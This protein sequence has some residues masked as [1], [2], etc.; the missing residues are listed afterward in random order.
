MPSL[1]TL[2][3]DLQ[4]ETGGFVSALNK[5]ASTAQRASKEIS[6]SFSRLGEIASQTFGAFGDFNPAISKLSFAMTAAG[7][8]AS[9]MMK[10]LRGVGGAIGPLAALGAGAGVGLAALAAGAVGVAIETAE[11]AAKMNELSKSTG[12]SASTLGAWTFAAKQSGLEGEQVV[13][14]LQLLSANMLKAAQAPAG[15]AT[16]FSRLGLNIRQS[17]GELKNA[18]DFMIELLGRLSEMS[19]KT[20]AVG[21]ARL[22]MGRGGASMLQL[23]DPE[24]LDR[25]IA[26]FKELNPQFDANAAAATKFKQTLGEISEVAAAAQNQLMGDLLP[27]LQALGTEMSEAIQSPNSDLAYLLK[28]VATVVKG[29]VAVGDT[30]VSAAEQIGLVIRH[31]A[32]VTIEYWRGVAEVGNRALHFDF[33]GMVNASKNAFATMKGDLSLFVADSKAIWKGNADF[34]QNIFGPAP[35]WTL[36]PHPDGGAG[37]GDKTKGAPAPTASREI[38]VVAKL[39][40]TLTAKSAAE[41]AA[42][43]ATE[44]GVAA[45]ALAKAAIEAETKIAETRASL[46]EKEKMLRDQLADARRGVGGAAAG[47]HALNFQAQIDGIE[48]LLAELDSAAPQ[49][50]TLY[51]EIA[52]G[53]FATKASKE[54]EQFT[55][56]TREETTAAE[57][58]TAAY[59]QGG[60]AIQAAMEAAK[61]A[62]FAELRDD[63]GELIAR[64]KEIGAPA[65]NIGKLQTA[66]DQLSAGIDGLRKA[67]AAD[68]S[69]KISEQIAKELALLSGEAKAYEVLAAAA[70]K[71]LAAQ[72]EAAA[73]AA[74]IKFGAEHRAATPQQIQQVSEMELARLSQQNKLTI[75]Q[76]A[77]QFDLA[78]SYQREIEKLSQV[79][80]YM[81]SLGEST[82]TV[83]AKMYETTVQAIQGWDKAAQAVGNLGEKF[84]AMANEI[85]LEGENTSG[86]FFEL[87]KKS[88]DG[89]S[90]ELAKFIVTGKANWKSF[91]DGIAEQMA[92]LA[93]QAGISKIFK[94]LS[95][96]LPGAPGQGAPG[97]TAGAASGSLGI[98]GAIAGAFGIKLPG[99]PG[100]RGPLGTAGDP[101]HVIA[102]GGALGGLA[103]SSPGAPE[104]GGSSGETDGLISKLS[105]SLEGIFSKL[106]SSLGSIVSSIG[107]ALGSMGSSIGSGVA[108]GFSSVIGLF[109]LA[110]GGPVTTGIPQI[111]GEKGMEI[112]VPRESG[113]IVP[114]LA[115]FAASPEVRSMAARFD[116]MNFPQLARREYGGDVSSG[117]PYLTGERRGEG[118]IPDSF[119][120]GGMAARADHPAGHAGGYTSVVNFSVHGVK[121]HDSFSRSKAQIYADQLNQQA[122]AHRRNRQ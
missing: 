36:P 70:G 51:A 52:S 93:I 97:G 112:F 28:T 4:A 91:L 24:E 82:L 98:G 111:V 45:S 23:G 47:E 22:T 44:K 8:A 39:I 84:R 118:F 103:P 21:F 20:A 59:S 1:G 19:D 31:W 109:G 26:K 14:S 68:E 57:L 37:S 102:A 110:G 15:V 120:S 34:I 60:A 100:G 66:F 106:T 65:A 85:V 72:R 53:E 9:A 75:A 113:R 117:I 29:I 73:Q 80:E 71:S 48:K 54:L 119:R 42:A 79:R 77:A 89:I 104:G 56:K 76:T 105:S 5:A 58:M 78:T 101:I 3:V 25:W 94:A 16:A 90:D 41:L 10:E 121:D 17:N 114:S 87:W 7:S 30:L 107:G 115:Q 95:P 86:K 38:D 46:L 81:Q 122:I 50:K 11:S 13:K 108:S 116:V 49:I 88:V 61:I 40:E 12:L 67:T 63:V 55:T 74:A 99:A 6:E 2:F 18:G 64:L 35:P 92:K 62:P 83:D 33:G 43:A 27:M 32:S 96:A 69:A